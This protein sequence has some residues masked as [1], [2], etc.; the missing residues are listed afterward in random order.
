MAKKKSL[1]IIEELR[2]AN[3]SVTEALSK[4]SL[5]AQLKA[6]DKEG[7]AIALILG[8]KEIF[9]ENIIIRDLKNSL[10]ESVP[11]ERM[12]DEIRKRLK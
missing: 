11:M 8:Q 9:E 3:I 2:H 10:Q 6:A 4:D 5:K 12:V 1:K 7:A